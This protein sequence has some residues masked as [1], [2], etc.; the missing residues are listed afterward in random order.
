ME[1]NIGQHYGE[2]DDK[3]IGSGSTLKKV[4]NK[5]GKG[6]LRKRYYAYVP[7]LKSQIKKK[8]N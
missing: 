6:N 2:V 5:Y 3:Y 8:L 7:H 1:K 4:I